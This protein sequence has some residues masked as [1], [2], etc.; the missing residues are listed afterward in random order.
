MKADSKNYLV[1][2][3]IAQKLQITP[4]FE[5]VNNEPK[6]SFVDCIKNGFVVIN[7]KHEPKDITKSMFE[8]LK[9]D[10]SRNNKTLFGNF[11]N[12]ENMTDA[13]YYTHQIL[14]YFSTYGL[15]SLGLQAHPY[16]PAK[17][18]WAGKDEILKDINEGKL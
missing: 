18:L 12:V 8:M 4:W 7:Y 17:E 14:H 13:E 5:L 1:F 16:I 15:E 6:V 10:F 3:K 2:D 9:S 11:E